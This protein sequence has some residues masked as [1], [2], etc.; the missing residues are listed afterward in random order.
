MG[1]SRQ[2]AA[3]AALATVEGMDRSP[4]TRLRS[5]LRASGGE[6]DAG[7]VQQLEQL[8]CEV[9]LLREEN[10]RLKVGREHVRDRPVNERVRAA[11][12]ALGGR[13]DPDGD[14]PWAV[15]T[16]CMLLRDELADACRELERGA[17]ELRGRLET[18]IPD[19]EGTSVGEGVRPEARTRSDFE[20]VV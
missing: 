7:A 8:E 5:W 20:G 13:D 4:G 14:E 10:A 16:E 19:A 6:K 9:A 11:L 17:R 2:G 18:L 1:D 12:P 3:E 15:L